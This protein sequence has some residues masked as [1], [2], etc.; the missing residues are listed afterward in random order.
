MKRKLFIIG[1]AAMVAACAFS[2]PQSVTLSAA[3]G[4][5]VTATSQSVRL[6]GYVDE[7]VLELPS[8]CLTGTV[9]VTATP[10]VGAAVTLATKTITAT[11]L[12]RPRLDGTTT[13]AVA[14]DSDPPSRYLS[15][16]DTFVANVTAANATGGTWRCFVKF[17]DGK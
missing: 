4:T 14:L 2:A 11:T 1:A 15:V 7:I 8:G 17:D 3:S 6:T 13:A 12:V 9:V 5:N 16:R 10:D